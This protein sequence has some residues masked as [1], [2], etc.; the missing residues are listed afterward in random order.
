MILGPWRRKK[1]LLVIL[2][3][4]RSCRYTKNGQGTLLPE[5]KPCLQLPTSVHLR[6]PFRHC[7]IL[8][9]CSTVA[10]QVNIIVVTQL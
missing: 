3:V 4:V 7:H 9:G 1:V 8:P 10:V 2:S 6:V 5:Q